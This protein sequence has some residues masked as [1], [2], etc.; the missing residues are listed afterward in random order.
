MNRPWFGVREPRVAEAFGTHMEAHL[1]MPIRPDRAGLAGRAIPVRSW[2]SL[3]GRVVRNALIAVAVMTMV[4]VGLV[5]V[6]GDR[7]ARMTNWSSNVSARTNFVSSTRAFGVA[8]DPSITPIQAGVALNALQYRESPNDQF[9]TIAPAKQPMRP[10]SANA[11]TPDMFVSARPDVYDGPSSRSIL[12]AV[13]KGFTPRE[14]AYL[15]ALSDPS[16]WHEFDMVARARAV[17]MIG[18]QLRLPFSAEALPQQRPLPSYG[19]SRSFAYAAVSRAAYLM[20]IGRTAEAEE[21]L[22]SIVSFGFAFIDNGTT[23]MDELIGTVIVGVGRDALQ[24]FYVIEHD[25]RADLPAL[26]PLKKAFFVGTNPKATR[27]VTADE[28]RQRLLARLADPTVP[29]PERFEAVEGL[30]MMSCTNVRGLLFGEGSEVTDAIARARGTL[31]RYPSE[32]ALIDIRTRLP[33]PSNLPVSAKVWQSVIVSPASVAGVVLH[34]PR[35][36]AC[37]LILGG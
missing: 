16:V 34:N 1:P 21:V 17:D 11:I 18:G 31:A 20:S 12:E 19:G 37:A 23:T 7:L 8:T 3:A 25:P 10:W 36:P 4:P 29:R 13:A 22:R 27:S 14:Q 2:W 15:K 32:R 9:V 5:A 28:L 33:S 6:R 26:A 30:S 24:R 35:M